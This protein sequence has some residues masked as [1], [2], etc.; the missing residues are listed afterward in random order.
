MKQR[1]EMFEHETARALLDQ[2]L[3]DSRLYKNSQ[4]YK[5][6]LDFVVKLRNFAPFN[7]MLLQI[8]K[9]GLSYAA[10]A[11]DWKTRFDRWPKEG[12]R[13]LLILW[14]FG[15]VALVYDI[16][17]TEGK[18]VP[19]DVASFFAV[20]PIDHIALAT[21]ERLTEKHGIE[22][23]A[24][25]AGD[26]NAGSIRVLTHA[27]DD[28]EPTLYRMHINRNHPPATQFATLA[29]E[30]GHLFL[31]HLGI[32]KKLGVRCRTDLE[33]A[34]RELEAESVCYIVCQRQKIFTN[35]EK[36][37]A[38]YVSAHMTINDVDIYQILHAAGQVEKLL[39]LA[40]TQNFRST[41]GHGEPNHI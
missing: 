29:H 4:D 12:A 30:L 8:Q 1:G 16:Q 22:W 11:H 3:I 18:D 24:V 39:G 6:L 36:Y 33:H 23:Y 28:K 32:D 25:D 20:G 13:P 35:S 37:L 7:A 26:K 14:P 19:R 5:S 21:F 31:G 34:A 38:D 41:K 2:L 10:S 27:R 9:P 15:P 17:D 40:G